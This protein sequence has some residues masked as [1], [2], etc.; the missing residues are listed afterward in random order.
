MFYPSPPKPGQDC[1]SGIGE[2]VDRVSGGVL[3]NCRANDLKQRGPPEQMA[4]NLSGGRRP[5]VL[6]QAKP[7]MRQQR[8]W[9]RARDQQRVVEPIVEEANIHVRFD[10]P[11][12]ARIE[13]AR[14][15]K[16]RVTHVSK[17]LHSN[18]SMISPKPSPIAI[19]KIKTI[20]LFVTQSA[21]LRQTFCQVDVHPLR[22][23]PGK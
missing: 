19:F 18:A 14:R 4:E 22:C 7:S 8:D 2:Y 16:Q 17:P 3:E 23:V 1:A 6:S 10:Q 5:I 13:N 12:I 21:A 20:P 15:H 11:A 9:Q